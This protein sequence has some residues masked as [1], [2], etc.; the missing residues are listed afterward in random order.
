MTDEQ[1]EIENGRYVDAFYVLPLSS[2]RIAVLTP[3]HD[4][5]SVVETWEEAI[6]AGRAMLKVFKTQPRLNV[7]D[8]TPRISLKGIKL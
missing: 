2:G 5:H 6:A 3:R 7:W 1:L 8:I 4:L